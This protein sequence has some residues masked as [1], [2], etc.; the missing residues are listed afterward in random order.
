MPFDL[1]AL[2][3][4]P[5]ASGV[6]I[7]K[8]SQGKILYVGK[9]KN[10]RQR[11]KQYFLQGR[12]TRAVIP[13]LITQIETI[14]F[15]I[16]T[17]EKEALLLE[18]NLI[19]KHQPKYNAS[20]KD[21]KSFF[22]LSINHKHQWPMIRVV[23]Y[24]GK[25]PSGALYFGPY[26]NGHA[27]RQTLELLRHLFPLRQCSDR[28]LINRTRPCILHALKRCIAPCVSKCTKEEYDAFVE[29]VIQFL[30]GHDSFI[31][32]ELQ[33][34]LERATRNL[35][36]EKADALLKMIRNIQI[37]L[38]RQRVEKADSVDR[39]VIG[40][41]R[42]G[43]DILLVQM[44]FREGKLTGTNEHFFPHNAQEESELIS[45]FI[46]QHYPDQNFPPHEIV[47]P[48]ELEEEDI[49]SS[50][51]SEAKKRKISIHH[52]IKGDK[53][54]LL[55]MANQNAQ[56][57]FRQTQEKKNPKEKI[58]MAMEEG[59]HLINYPE[60]IECFDHSNISG[61]EPVSAMVVFQEG[62]KTPK[63][64]RK[65]RTREANPG[66]D[67]GALKEV[68]NRRYRKAKEEDNLPDLILIDGG[69]GHLN[70][71]LAILAQLDISTVDVVSIA[72]EEGKHSR[73]M[74]QEKIF[75]TSREEPLILPMNSPI[76]FFLQEVRDEAHRFAITFQRLRRKKKSL[77]SALDHIPGIGP[78]KRKRLLLHFGSL[79][80][81]LEA[82]VEELLKI[83]GIS[84][85]DVE[86][87]KNWKM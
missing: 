64:Y 41:H 39:D 68:L 35:E 27:A 11:I 57:K 67:Y 9:A 42:E 61:T 38:E 40:L 55:E 74:T 49:L 10:L 78:V 60:K 77:G 59:F 84:Q 24:K 48:V 83:K 34:E 62:E 5:T 85:K 43:S 26:T 37:T 1:S 7:M 33:E 46:L 72:K 82:S 87:L 29:K 3:H 81:I 86:T 32:Q 79:K 75:I 15:I 36:F 45:S 21:D 2:N 13:Y 25:P 17:S 76:L 44:L 54:T 52:P 23:R 4:F 14:D 20:L 22:S 8:N 18:N 16:V 53:K 80:R 69:K 56:A 70:T 50:L 73:G 63:S 47:I 30:R 58:L 66:D 71:A 65:F 31:L 12:D 6:Y 19:K 51:I 28:E